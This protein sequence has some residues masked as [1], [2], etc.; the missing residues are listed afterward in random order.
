MEGGK[1]DLEGN[2]G[3]GK[4]DFSPLGSVCVIHPLVCQ[5]RFCGNVW[6]STRVIRCPF[7]EGGNICF[8]PISVKNHP[9]FNFGWLESHGFDFLEARLEVEV[10]R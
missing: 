6:T 8:V 10:C 9:G 4:E 7:C 2:G 1:I 5:C 3:K